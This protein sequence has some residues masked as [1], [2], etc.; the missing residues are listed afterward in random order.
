MS[1]KMT[2]KLKQLAEENGG[3]IYQDLVFS[4]RP[5]VRF[6]NSPA[7]DHLERTFFRYPYTRYYGGERE[8]MLVQAKDPADE[9]DFIT[10]R[11]EELVKRTGTATGISPWSAGIFRD[12][13][14]RSRE[15]LKRIGSRCS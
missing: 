2:G 6:R 11:I 10:N 5:L 8:I 12:M 9:I 14:G 4:K 3:K 1:R 15:A 7:L 13:A